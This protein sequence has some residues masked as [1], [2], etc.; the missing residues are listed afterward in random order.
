MF[1]HSRP[2][3][4][5]SPGAAETAL[6]AV[7]LQG[8]GAYGAFS[9]GVL[10][11][12]F[13]DPGFV[14]KAFSGASAGAVNAVVAA[15]GY[16][17][18][19]APGA[20]EALR[21]IW[22]TISQMSLLAP[23]DLP[24]FDLQLDFLTRLVSPYQFNPLNINPLRDAVG[25]IVDFERLA[26]ES[27]I[28]LF[29][30]A[31]DVSTGDQRIFRENEVTLDAVMASCCLPSLFQAVEIDGRAYWD[32]GFSSNPPILPMV[33]ETP[34]RALLLVKLNA[35]A[36][37]EIPTGAADITGRLRRILINAPLLHDLDALR[38]MQKQL[39][40]TSLLPADLR[41]VRDLSIETIAIQ[42]ELLTG[43]DS[44]YGPRPQ[45]V[46]KLWESGRAAADELL[47]RQSGESG[48]AGEP[49]VATSA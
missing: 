43:G 24:G 1:R 31:T 35:D 37:P 41:R 32:G 13:E 16:L 26:R 11:R 38:L 12:L 20:R 30:S 33:L 14:P 5:K 28:P 21:Q 10:D 15:W 40:R 7:A 27:R 46:E 8:G 48:A 47:V 18:D 36:E 29:V 44:A 34:T 49:Q 19:G 42:P 23:T 17:Q 3:R 6:P 22:T 4:P 39:R 25:G 2:R 9:W 45:F